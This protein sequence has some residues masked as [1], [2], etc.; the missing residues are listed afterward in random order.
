MYD[1]LRV[2]KLLVQSLIQLFINRPV[3]RLLVV[4]VHISLSQ[5]IV[6]LF[7]DRFVVFHS[8]A[9]RYDLW[10]RDDYHPTDDIG[11]GQIPRDAQQRA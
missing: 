6:D 4:Y 10:S 11:D 7:C 9:L 5:L 2:G 1:D 8:S 3:G